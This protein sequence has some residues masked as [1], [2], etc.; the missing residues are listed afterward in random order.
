[1]RPIETG[2][3]ATCRVRVDEARTIDFLGD[4]LRVYA[5]PAFVRDVEEA[6]RAL[7]L[8]YAGPEETSVGTGIDLTHSAATPLGMN[9]EIT[10]AVAGVEGRR[11]DFQVIARDEAEEIGRG[12]HSRVI[13]PVAKLGARVAA[14]A[15]KPAAG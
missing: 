6:C 5:T 14:K 8:D 13:V 4:E 15:A 3:R 7:L 11:V 12:E 9:V 2:T 10:V 1:M